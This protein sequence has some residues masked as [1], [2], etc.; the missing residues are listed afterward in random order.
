M[1]IQIWIIFIGICAATASCTSKTSK[2][3]ISDYEVAMELLAQGRNDEAI[4]LMDE[5]LSN[6]PRDMRARR[7]LANAYAARAG[8]YLADFTDFARLL[9]ETSNEVDALLDRQGGLLSQL[10]GRGDDQS[11]IVMAFARIMRATLRI[12]GLMRSFEFLPVPHTP[13]QWRDLQAAITVLDGEPRYRGG[14]ALYRALLRISF[15][16][17]DLH[18]RY[19]FSHLR[20]CSMNVRKLARQVDDIRVD[21]S[22][23]LRDI[24]FGTVD[25]ESQRRILEFVRKMD[26]DMRV[27]VAALNQ[28]DQRDVDVSV[29]VKKLHGS[30]RND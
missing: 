11:R 10:K 9:I 14:P 30:C 4:Q 27:A 16:K 18:D 1:R 12:D 13:E 19:D 17:Y 29:I 26:L 22:R 24:S 23:I 2:Q 21:V 7:L 5:R 25:K 20:K 3:Q 6:N 15:F 28:L 8:I